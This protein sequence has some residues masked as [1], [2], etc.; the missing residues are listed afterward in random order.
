MQVKRSEIMEGCQS[1][2]ERLAHNIAVN[3]AVQEVFAQG[4]NVTHIEHAR[5]ESRIMCGN[6]IVGVVPKPRSLW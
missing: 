2:E 5:K 1:E 3:K 4:K 6:E